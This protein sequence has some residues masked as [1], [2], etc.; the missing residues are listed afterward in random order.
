MSMTSLEDLDVPDYSLVSWR[1]SGD[2][3]YT[4]G[5]ALDGK[6]WSLTGVPGIEGDVL[7]A[8]L[9]AQDEGV[10]AVAERVRS[11]SAIGPMDLADVELGPPVPRPDKILCMGL[12]YANHAAGAGFEVPAVP[13]FF[14]KFRNCLLGP[15]GAI[16]MPRVSS[17]IDFEGELAVVIGRR[18]K[19]VDRDDALQYVAGYS[20]FNDVSARD[21]Q[22]QTSQWIAGKAL[23]TF[24]P[25][26][27]GLVPA[28][29]VPDPQNLVIKTTVNGEIKQNDSTADMIF[30]VAETIAHIS[31]LMTLEPGDIIATGTPAGVAYE[32]NPTPYLLVGDVVE[33]SIAGLGTLRN[34]VVPESDIEP[35][36][37]RHD[38]DAHPDPVA[39]PGTR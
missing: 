37:S 11:D 32:K 26:G 25:M 29:L 5:L 14:S 39:S 10:E 13:V 31:S 7:A 19:H 16:V 4:G 27:P 8:C 22:L 2:R 18:T 3:E 30:G 34:P 36:G 28:A 17:D 12:N 35:E 15:R 24:A 23:D 33:V 1:R 20:V 21:I 6:V 9:A 38:I